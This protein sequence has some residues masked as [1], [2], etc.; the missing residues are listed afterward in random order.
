MK[1]QHNVPKETIKKFKERDKRISF[2]LKFI[3]KVMNNKKLNK[4]E[5]EYALKIL[6]EKPVKR[7]P[8][9]SR[10]IKRNETNEK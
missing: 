4:K 8:T 6:K 10:R 9:S 1:L 3:N 5:K 2:L 7:R